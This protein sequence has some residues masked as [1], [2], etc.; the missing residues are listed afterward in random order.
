MLCYCLAVLVTTLVLLLLIN[1][2]L[3]LDSIRAIKPR[4]NKCKL[5]IVHQNIGRILY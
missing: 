3:D 5:T 1:L 2:D 4:L